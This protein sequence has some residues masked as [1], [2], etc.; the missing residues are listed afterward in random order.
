MVYQECEHP[1]YAAVSLD[2]AAGQRVQAHEL[3]DRIIRVTT[4]REPEPNM[5][6]EYRVLR[7]EFMKGEKNGN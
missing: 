7:E 1:W 4:G 5:S 6:E 3:L 2:L